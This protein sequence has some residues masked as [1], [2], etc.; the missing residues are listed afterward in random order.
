MYGA[1]YAWIVFGRLSPTN[2]LKIVKSR[3]HIDCT[4]EQLKEFMQGIFSVEQLSLRRDNIT[5][6]SGLVSLMI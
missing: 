6:I 5:T 3:V 1:N 2:I 4:R